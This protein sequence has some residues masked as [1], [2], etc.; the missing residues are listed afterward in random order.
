[1]ETETCPYMH[2]EG[3]AVAHLI[4]VLPIPG[5]FARPGIQVISPHVV[6]NSPVPSA[7]TVLILEKAD[8]T[9][10][11]LEEELNREEECNHRHCDSACARESTPASYTLRLLLMEQASH[12]SKTEE[13][14][15]R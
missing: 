4:G 6:I 12:L 1:M 15:T 13:V 3:H 2:S 7:L 8:Y 10:G 11:E 9:C 14:R 5:D